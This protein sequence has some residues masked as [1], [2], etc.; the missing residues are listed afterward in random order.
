MPTSLFFESVKSSLDTRLV[1]SLVDFIIIVSHLMSYFHSSPNPS[2]LSTLSSC[3]RI[4]IDFHT[5]SHFYFCMWWLYGSVEIANKSSATSWK[6]LSEMEITLCDCCDISGVWLFS[7]SVILFNISQRSHPTSRRLRW[8]WLCRVIFILF[9][10]LRTLAKRVVR[11]WIVGEY[12]T[13]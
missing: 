12:F 2:S 6:H 8:W 4:I 7:N 1:K 13:F 5:H 10:L 9:P 11:R 3:I